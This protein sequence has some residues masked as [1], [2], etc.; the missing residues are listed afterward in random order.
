M[1]T[2]KITPQKAVGV[3]KVDFF[4]E[5]GNDAIAKA[6]SNKIV[7]ME[8]RT[9]KENGSILLKSGAKLIK[10]FGDYYISGYA[11][12]GSDVDCYM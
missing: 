10:D 3:L 12:D 4:K 8:M 9:V 7:V 6:M 2:I 1:K 11:E 5:H